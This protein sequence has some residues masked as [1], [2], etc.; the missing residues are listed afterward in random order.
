MLYSNFY[1]VQGKLIKLGLLTLVDF[2]PGTE[3]DSIKQN[4][5]EQTDQD[6]VVTNG[7]KTKLGELSTDYHRMKV[8]AITAIENTTLSTP[9]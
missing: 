6:I 2:M 8:V 4:V 7:L 3:L 1:F 5:F 9:P